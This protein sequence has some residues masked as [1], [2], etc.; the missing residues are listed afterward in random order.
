MSLRTC[1]LSIIL[2]M[3]KSSDEEE[4]EVKFFLLLRKSLHLHLEKVSISF[5]TSEDVLKIEDRAVRAVP[6]RNWN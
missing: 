6:C 4:E 1:N 2:I 5:N 3:K